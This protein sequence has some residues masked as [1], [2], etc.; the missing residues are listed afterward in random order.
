MN[1]LSNTNKF[2]AS[3]IAVSFAAIFFILEFGI[4]FV[5]LPFA[6][7]FFTFIFRSTKNWLLFFIY[8]IPIWSNLSAKGINPLD[9]GI[10]SIWI[11]GLLIWFINKIIFEKRTIIRNLAD[12]FILFFF[13]MYIFHLIMGVGFETSK[14]TTSLSEYLRASII[15]FYFPI[16]D[17]FNG[18][19]KLKE[20]ATH[21]VITLIISYVFWGVLNYIR[22]TNAKNI[23]EV[24][25]FERTNQEIF[26]GGVIFGSIFYLTIKGMQKKF[27]FLIFTITSGVALIVTISRVY[28]LTTAMGLF[29]AFLS[30]DIK[31]KVNI[32]LIF[33]VLLLIFIVSLQLIAPQLSE[34][35][36]T[37]FEKRLT[38][39]FD[40]TTDKSFLSR[41][42]EF[43]KLFK[44]R[45]EY[46][47]GGTGLAYEYSYY[48]SSFDLYNW[49]SPYVH[50][51]YIHLSYKAGIPMALVYFSVLFYYC[52]YGFQR[53]SKKNEIWINSLY[54]ASSVCIAIF[55]IVN[56]ITSTFSS[57]PGGVYLALIIAFIGI[58]DSI[59]NDKR[60]R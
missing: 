30:F 41:F 54:L 17:E 42:D 53:I 28:W 55:L 22:I 24:T 50:N 33:I 5:A 34:Y 32:L 59:R 12:W 4:F 26:S 56:L 27:V 60:Q 25:R 52:F 39:S 1:S 40:L 9:V 48:N 14:L 31:R 29:L 11:I 51:S 36:I 21:L 18:K 19:E 10:L 49:V 6:F 43:A 44:W 7:L 58:A 15:L 38:S 46:F 3:F 13:V 35:L 23:Y 16:R 8:T 47:F 45:G 20:L 57:R 37:F 2:L